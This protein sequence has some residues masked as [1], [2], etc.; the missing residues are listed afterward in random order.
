MTF[1]VVAPERRRHDRDMAKLTLVIPW[2]AA[3]LVGCATP[4]PPTSPAEDPSLPE[5]EV[6]EPEP[7]DPDQTEME[8]AEPDSTEPEATDPAD[9]EPSSP[10]DEAPATPK[11]SDHKKSRCKVTQGCAWRDGAGPGKAGECIEHSSDL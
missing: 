7:I 9:T 4:P 11:C 5:P 6:V 1:G 2:L 10:P 8:V 3:C